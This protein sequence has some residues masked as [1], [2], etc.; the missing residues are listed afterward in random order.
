MEE[1]KKFVGLFG[2]FSLG[3]IV[4][5]SLYI[6]IGVFG[7]LKYGEEIKATITLNLP[8]EQK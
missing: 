2:L 5:I 1:P 3:M 4:I 6:I 7:Y 8:Q